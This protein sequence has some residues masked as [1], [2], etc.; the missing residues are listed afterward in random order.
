MKTLSLVVLLTL[1][2]C[3]SDPAA[4]PA[5][6]CVTADGASYCARADGTDG[7]DDRVCWR[8]EAG[9]TTQQQ[10]YACATEANGWQAET[11][12]IDSPSTDACQ[13]FF[14]DNPACCYA[15]PEHVWVGGTSIP[16]GG[17]GGWRML[18]TVNTYGVH[19]IVSTFDCH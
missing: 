3:G 2:A 18:D 7:T 10:G 8:A 17:H 4:K 9:C 6:H 12:C 15:N 11:G 19:P 16:E 13:A 14:A 1:A 5:G